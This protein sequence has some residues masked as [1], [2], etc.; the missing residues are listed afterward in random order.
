MLHELGLAIELVGQDRFAAAHK[1]MSRIS[2]I[3]SV[4]TLSW[5]VLATLTPVRYPRFA[6]CSGPRPASVGPVSRA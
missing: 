1:A 2:R 3:Q 6:M 4:M 5:E